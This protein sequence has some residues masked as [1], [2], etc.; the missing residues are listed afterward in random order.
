MT[1]K[2]HLIISTIQYDI[3]DEPI[4]EEVEAYCRVI[5]G[6]YYVSYDSVTVRAPESVELEEDTEQD[7]RSKEIIKLDRRGIEVRR[8]GNV[9]GRIFYY[10]G[11]KR[12][13][14]LDLG[15]STLVVKNITESYD[16]TETDDL[17]EAEAVYDLYLNGEY[18]SKCRMQIRLELTGENE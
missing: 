7:A 10:P 11:E 15:F 9:T 12:V 5:D 1:G 18:V 4:V 3:A 6:S 14:E 17:L 2:C 8:R 13:S 16:I